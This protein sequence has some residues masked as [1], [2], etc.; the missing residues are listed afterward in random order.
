[1]Q[2]SQPFIRTE[3]LIGPQNMEKLR[4]SRVLLFGVGGV[5]GHCAEALARCGIGHFTLVDGDEVTVTNL[6]RQAVAFR[7]TLGLRKVDVMR[8]RILDIHPEAS[9][10][11]LPFFYLPSETH[12]V[13][14]SPFD[15]VIDAI[16]TVTAKVDIAVQAQTRGIRCVSCMGAGNRLDPGLFEAADLYDTSACPLC[17]VMR[18]LCRQR[19]VERLQVIYSKEPPARPPGTLLR[20]VSG[21]PSPGSISYV[22]ASA[23]LRLTAESVRLLLET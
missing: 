21:R 13:W 7:S 16:D 9:V 14:D 8:S 12:G 4:K 23:G 5:G 6:N 3:M 17:R 18:K 15:L 19:G 2:E 1:M 11:A 10:E 22:T 20:P